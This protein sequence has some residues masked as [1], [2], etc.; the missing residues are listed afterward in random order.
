MEKPNHENYFGLFLGLIASTWA[1]AQTAEHYITTSDGVELY[2]RKSGQGAIC[3]FVHG[4][5]GM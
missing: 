4:G 1:A 3:I 5:P 2:T